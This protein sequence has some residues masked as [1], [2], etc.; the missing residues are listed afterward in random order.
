MNLAAGQ[1]HPAE[2]MDT[3]FATQALSI[4]YLAKNWKK[5][6]PTVHSIPEETDNEIA[7]IKLRTMGIS[8][9]KLSKEQKKYL[10]GWEEGT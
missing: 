1:G 7:S 8:I 6:T 9:D 10:G 3:S 5:M 2:I 4:E